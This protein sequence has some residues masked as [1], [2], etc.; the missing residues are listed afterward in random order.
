M[1]PGRMT[2]GPDPESE[3]HTGGE[4]GAAPKRVFVDARWTRTDFPDGI[5]RYGA[6]IIEALH[7]LRPVTML[8]HD[9][10]QLRLLPEGVPYRL[11]NSPFS[12]RELL[13]SRTL[14]RLGAEVVFSPLQVIGGFRR[15]YVLVLTLH[16]LIYYRDPRP[17]GFLPLP[18]RV[19]WWLFHHAWW[20]QR[21]LLNRA[22]AV[23]TVS[24]TTKRLIAR[25]RLTVRSVTVVPNAPGDAP[26]SVVRTDTATGLTESSAVEP[27][28]AVV[29]EPEPGAGAPRREL[30]YMGS[31]MPYKNVET[32]LAGMARLP[33]YRLHLLSRIPPGR[34]RELRRIVPSDAE[35]VFHNG[36]EESAYRLLLRRAAALVTAS[37]D[38]GFGLPV[39]EAMNAETPVVCSDIPIFREV[40]G[41][42]AWFFDPDSAADFATAVRRTENVEPRGSVVAAARAHAAGFT[43]EASARR[44]SELISRLEHRSA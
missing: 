22:D 3:P 40:S 37:R 17:P 12:P 8:I 7:R 23:V 43:W 9:R 32:L 1:T 28:E 38:E 18:V 5:S 25:H 31:F 42:N 6:G 27:G 41:G 26:V 20:P 19:V 33:G 29:D 44:L 16:D 15:R 11:I 24:D 34:E 14:R 13:L 4:Y 21:L 36:I 35:V 39:I 2:P 10:R 30:L